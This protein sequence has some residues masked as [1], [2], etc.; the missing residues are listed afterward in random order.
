MPLSWLATESRF[1]LLLLLV[2]LLGW[3]AY[4]EAHA[5][6]GACTGTGA[7]RAGTRSGSG[8]GKRASPFETIGGL[9]GEDSRVS[10]ERC[11]S[12]DNLRSG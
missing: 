2:L 6:F 9:G 7:G 10:M 3:L 1:D 12:G 11:W 4:C 5:A 8:R